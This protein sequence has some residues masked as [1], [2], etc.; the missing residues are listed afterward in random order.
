[1]SNI[2]WSGKLKVDVYKRQEQ[3]FALFLVFVLP[4]DGF[5]PLGKAGIADEPLLPLANHSPDRQMC[6]RDSLASISL[7][8][9]VFSRSPGM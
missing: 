7:P 5:Q 1:M 2:S 3:R 6:I 8:I 9:G 4:L